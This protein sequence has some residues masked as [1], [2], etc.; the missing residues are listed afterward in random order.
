VVS[1]SYNR[2]SDGSRH[3]V[4]ASSGAIAA[5]QSLGWCW[6]NVVQIGAAAA[7]GGLI[8]GFT[9]WAT[10]GLALGYGA[11]AIAGSASG[12]VGSLAGTLVIGQP[13]NTR[14][15]Q[16]AGLQATIGMFA[17][18][19]ALPAYA[20]L[21]V[22]NQAAASALLSSGAQMGMNAVVSTNS[23]GFGFANVVK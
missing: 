4:G 19:A 23:G 6:G 5:G 15:F 14:A 20:P 17:G 12:F 7:V 18:L 2:A 1:S 3:M 11:T 13:L 8:G 16:N 9:G 10:G 21:A 22:G